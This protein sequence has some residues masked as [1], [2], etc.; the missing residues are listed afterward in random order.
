MSGGHWAYNIR[1][2]GAT[3]LLHHYILSYIGEDRP[4]LVEELSAII[5]NNQGSWLESRMANLSGQFTG[6]VRLSVAAENAESLEQDIRAAQKDDL[7]LTLSRAE[8]IGA[9][10]RQRLL[11]KVI[12]ADR[13][14]IIKELAA[15]LARLNVN[16]EDLQTD[17][18]AAAMAGEPIFEAV[19]EVSA[20]SM[21]D[22]DRLRDELES[23]S[24]D[25]I[26]EVSNEA[27]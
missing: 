24:D 19:V 15:Q 9:A 22:Q 23:L 10:S 20:T 1:K 13:P 18:R 3:V 5:A 11:I 6:V 21:L 25:L 14:G 12:G 7:M 4:G 26:V 8:P 17:V 16:V 27:I 2:G